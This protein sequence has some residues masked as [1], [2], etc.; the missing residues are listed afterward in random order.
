M[1]APL[2]VLIVAALFGAATFFM[3][4]SIAWTH[5][6]ELSAADFMKL[7]LREF[8]LRLKQFNNNIKNTA[9]RKTIGSGKEFK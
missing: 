9:D 7:I 3:L 8:R 5:K 4:L 1:M 2:V 6:P